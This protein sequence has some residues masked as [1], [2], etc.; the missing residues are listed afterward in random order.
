MVMLAV[1]AAA[2][3]TLVLTSGR[4]AGLE[5]SILETIDAQGTRSIHVQAM[6]EQVALPT[7]IVDDLARAEAVEEVVGWGRTE[8]ATAAG[9]PDGTRVAVRHAYGTL[10]GIHLTRRPG[11]DAPAYSTPAAATA[12]GLPPGAGSVRLI[13]G[14]EYVLSGRLDLPEH[15][16]SLEP[17]VVVAP[18]DEALTLTSID[19]LSTSAESLPALMRLVRGYLEDY[20]PDEVTVSTSEQWATLRSAIG[21]ELATQGRAIIGAVTGAAA[22]FALVVASGFVL[23]NRKDFGRRRALGATRTTIVALVAGQVF[24]AVALGAAV[25]AVAGGSW[26]ALE[27]SPTPPATYLVAIIVLITSAA[28]G[29]AAL[30][31]V[32]AARRDPVREL[33]VP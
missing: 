10:A 14:P 4:S 7:T 11:G 32:A 24:T 23:G 20:G 19:I 1:V 33:R 29:A 25:G 27:G 13:D 12:L 22:L 28:T 8:D 16:H 2:T 26:L 5:A 6:N 15:L 30:P 17:I 3:A 18:T 21:G 31:G 9:I